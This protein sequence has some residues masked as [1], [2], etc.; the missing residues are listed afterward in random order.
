MKKENPTPAVKELV[1]SSA[2]VTGFY[3]WELTTEKITPSANGLIKRKQNVYAI[4]RGAH[5]AR[6]REYNYNKS[7]N[8]LDMD[9]F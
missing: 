4:K 8:L 7:I 1:Y 5:L 6:I 9:A 2:V 3:Y